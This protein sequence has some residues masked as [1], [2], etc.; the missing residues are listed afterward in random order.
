MNC[1]YAINYCSGQADLRETFLARPVL[2]SNA[3]A[4]PEPQSVAGWPTG[5]EGVDACALAAFLVDRFSTWAKRADFAS[6]RI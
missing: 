4:F 1:Q 5:C 3:V 2:A 6:P